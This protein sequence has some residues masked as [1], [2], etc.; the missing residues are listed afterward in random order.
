M[1]KRELQ[2]EKMTG[3]QK[4]SVFLMAMGEEY[5]SKIMQKMETD[6]INAVAAHMKEIQ[7][8]P[9]NVLTSVFEEFVGKIQDNDQLIIQGDSFLKNVIGKSFDKNKVKDIYRDMENSEQEEPFAYIDKVDP[10]ALVRIIAG[11][12]PQTVA[13][14]LA[15]MRPGQAADVLSGLPKE[16]Q[17]NVA[18]RI[19]DI[20]Q[21]PIE[22]IN[23]VDNSLQ[24][25]VMTIG[26]SGGREIGG[27]EAVA[28]IL[29]EVDKATE[30]A[31]MGSMEEERTELAEKVRQLMF[32]FEDLI[33]VDDRGIREILKQV[34]T[35]E[36]VVALKSASDAMREK[37]FSNLSQRA[38]EMLREDME[39]MGPMRLAEVEAAQQGVIRI[40][41]QLEGDGKIII[42]RGSEDVLV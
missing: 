4:A 13:L 30:E 42:A 26:D 35:Q 24:K 9:S 17:G 22:I 11:E 36:L 27:T 23:E 16:I 10:Q 19:A 21:V 34:D 5:T 37:I 28:N 41:R 25:E 12:H 2:Y 6:Q 29:N 7:I 3:P 20:H 39:V 40:A 33:K 18:M 31:V 14:I 32:V 38:A 1:A 8:V 15:H